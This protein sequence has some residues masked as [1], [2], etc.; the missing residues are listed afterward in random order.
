MKKVDAVM[1]LRFFGTQILSSCFGFTSMLFKPSVTTFKST[2]QK[3]TL[4][5]SERVSS[6]ESQLSLEMVE[7]EMLDLFEPMAFDERREFLR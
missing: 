7:L 6:Y 1:F 4:R 5:M 3:K 2:T